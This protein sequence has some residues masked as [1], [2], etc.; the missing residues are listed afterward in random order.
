MNVATTAAHA[1]EP[2]SAPAYEK[3]PG[4]EIATW[5]P[6]SELLKLDKEL[7]SNGSSVKPGL[8]PLMV[9]DTVTKPIAPMASS[10]PLDVVPVRPLLGLVL[11]PEAEVA[12]SSEDAPPTS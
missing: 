10:F 12:V 2:E 3:V 4:A 1:C 5:P 9:A 6:C 8:R 7:R 11:V